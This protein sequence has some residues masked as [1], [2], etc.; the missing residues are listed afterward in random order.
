[1]LSAGAIAAAVLAPV[2]AVAVAAPSKT[3]AISDPKGDVDDGPDIQRA[4]LGLASDGRLRAVVTLAEKVDP[5]R[6]ARPLGAARLD[7][8]EDLDRERRRPGR[9]A[10][11][12]GSCA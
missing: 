7:L 3:V 11:P 6:A 10:P 12:T 9:D 4:Q 5:G 8:R 1:M 2:V